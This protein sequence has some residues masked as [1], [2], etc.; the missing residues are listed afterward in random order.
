MKWFFLCCLVTALTGAPAYA[1]EVYRVEK[2]IN[3]HTL[4]LSNQK[5]VRLI[6]IEAS[7]EESILFMRDLVEGKGVKLEYDQ[8]KE[9]SAGNLQAYVLL[10]ETNLNATLVYAGYAVPVSTPPNTT[11]DELFAMLY[12]DARENQRGLW[13]KQ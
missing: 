12:L 7:A 1:A 9:D 3:G 5:T 2:V 13:A 10:I 8:E 6:G 11:H 4:L